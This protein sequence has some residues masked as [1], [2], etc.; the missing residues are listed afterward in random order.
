MSEEIKIGG[1]CDPQ[2]KQVKK[3][4]VSHFKKGWEDGASF[5]VTVN[6]K[7]VVDLWAGYADEAHTVPWGK[8]TIV[9]TYSTTKIMA[10]I[11]GLLLSD[12]GLLDF[13]AP[14]SKY[15]P[16][17]AQ[18]GKEK[19]PVKYLFAHMSGL[20]GIEEVISYEDYYDWGKITKLLAEQKPWWEPGTKAGYHSITHGY[21]IGELIRRITDKTLG[22]FFREEIAEPLKADFYVGLLKK[23]DNR[24]ADLV[25]DPNQPGGSYIRL[26]Q[27]VADLAN[28]SNKLK[29]EIG[30]WEK[31]FQIKA[32]GEDVCYLKTY[33]ST[34]L[35][36]EGTVQNPD[37]VFRTLKN[38]SN[39]IFLLF[40]HVKESPDFVNRN[41]LIECKSEYVDKLRRIF[42]Y[43]ITDAMKNGSIGMK[44]YLNALSLRRRTSDWAW[45]SAEI[46]AINGH[47]N[48]RSTAKIGA[49]I[50]CQGEVDGI[51]F[52]SK[53]TCANI[54][55]EEQF[56]GI[57][58]VNGGLERYGMGLG[59]KSERRQFPNDKVCNWGGTGGSR[60]IMD[61]KNKLSFA[62]I[63]NRMRI[64]T[65]EETKK[66]MMISDTRAN[67]LAVAV[68]KSLG[69]L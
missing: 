33:N 48:A 42:D 34:L 28:T 60:V 15:W 68:Y 16:E 37:G 65:P 17:F 12:R 21:L 69:Q 13:E 24:V 62:Y 59:L 20:A 43:I 3:T 39:M 45:K 18:N 32:G 63:M 5:A 54:L 6:G 55:M 30:D 57:D 41:L 61:Q 58:V 1:F 47:G 27:A 26:F 29:E 10:V 51:R 67:N 40:P 22:N 36:E 9:C 53:H 7:F 56:K 23:D 4:F 38:H 52:L 35:F 25:T 11:C 49:I 8:D 66:N 44:M 50:A 46:P 14:V 64:Q 31:N 2:F 19:M